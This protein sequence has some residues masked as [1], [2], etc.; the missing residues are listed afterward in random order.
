MKL[1]HKK[2]ISFVIPCYREEENV[3]HVFRETNM[4][5]K[6]T[7]GYLWEMI[8]VDNGSTDKTRQNIENISRKNKNV[9]G[10]FLS[11]N[12]GP[13]SS[14]HCGLDHSSGDAVV[15]L[16]ADLQDPVDLVLDFIKKWE[17]GFQVVVGVRT[18]IEDNFVMTFLRRSFYQILKQI[19][20]IYIPINCGSYG[21][22]DKKVLSAIQSLPEKYRMFRGLRAW[23]GFKTAFV[24][25][26]RT[27]RQRGKSSYNFFRYV[28]HAER[29]FF[30]FSYLPLDLMVYFGLFLVL[31]SLIFI[32]FYLMFFFLFGNPIKGS[33][34][35]LTSVV[36]LGGMQ[37]LAISI[38]GKYV[39]VIVEETKNRPVYIIDKIVGKKLKAT[40][41]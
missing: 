19:S 35:I 14:V 40:S 25:Y 21:L 34:T 29:S 27:K 32:I 8:F 16:E 20:D 24:K 15:I 39:Q 17:E 6:K 12:F 36:F 2:T 33:V 11:R 31:M 22:I 4:L 41:R 30:G 9:S 28:R 38:I 7:D 10:I 23:V 3:E 18:Q 1:T 37:L 26:K 5:M 13:E